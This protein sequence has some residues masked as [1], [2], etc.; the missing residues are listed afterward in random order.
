MQ[1]ELDSALL[2][3]ILFFMEDQNGEFYVD[4]QEGIV[5]SGDDEKINS[6]EIEADN[7]RYL[8]L[9][10]WGPTDGFR[11]MEKFAASL[12]NA[13]TREELSAALDRG[14]GVFRAFKNT[15]A[16]Y[17]ETEKLW[18]A[19]KEREM[20]R[21]IVAWYNSL[22]ELWGLEL[23]GEEPEDITGLALE[24]FRFR[25]GTEL[26]AAL[27]EE[28]HRACLEE[29]NAQIS[30]GGR[31]GAQETVEEIFCG[32]GE[33]AFPGSISF[34]A[35]TAGG[36]FTG[37]VSAVNVSCEAARVCA[38]EVK[39]EYRGLGLGKALIALLLEQAVSKKIPRIIIDLPAGQEHFSRTLL[40]E[41]FKPCVRRFCRDNNG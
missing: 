9:P 37:Y 5:L 21:V 12:K 26:D 33:W 40:R 17:P 19:Y 3:Q 16:R 14:R 23:I 2:D 6:D 41:N 8:S 20:K 10:D 36:E 35:E 13:L 34:A 27:A 18:Y 31:P 4:T 25:A 11:L 39:P 32:M 38:V 29:F 24:D 15:L 7:G 28:L 22:R 1:F 30:S